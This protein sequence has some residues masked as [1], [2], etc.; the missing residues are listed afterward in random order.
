MLLLLL[1]LL[2]EIGRGGV[3]RPAGVA[4]SVSRGRYRRLLRVGNREEVALVTA[5]GRAKDRVM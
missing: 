3:T 5:Y 4:F 1:L 2:S